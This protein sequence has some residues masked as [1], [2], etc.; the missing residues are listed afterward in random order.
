MNNLTPQKR[1]DKN[2]RLVTRHVLSSKNTAA[3]NI[4]SVQ[5]PPRIE[6]QVR[7]FQKLHPFWK[8]LKQHEMDALYPVAL[9]IAPAMEKGG[10][11]YYISTI[12]TE[13]PNWVDQITAVSHFI[14]RIGPVKDAD[15]TSR[16]LYHASRYHG[17]TES[18]IPFQDELIQKRVDDVLRLVEESRFAH[19]FID[20][21]GPSEVAFQQEN[22]TKRLC[23]GVS[24]GE[25]ES[26]T[27]ALDDLSEFIDFQDG[28]AEKDEVRENLQYDELIDY[29]MYVRETGK[30]TSQ[31]ALDM[32]KNQKY[33]VAAAK[34]MLDNYDGASVL[35][36]GTL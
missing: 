17:V 10:F 33:N 34:E 4:P 26:L 29:I 30:T 7:A 35:I 13:D 31:H 9:I 21:R 12:D 14:N 24:A 6:D 32:V 19:A 36:D 2:G 23:V 28:E 11:S 22:F 18:E 3:K 16:T 20:E 8:S 25:H 5:T 1:M 27:I 15:T